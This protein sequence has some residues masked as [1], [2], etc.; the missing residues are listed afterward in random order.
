MRLHEKGGR[1]HEMPLNHNL[2]AYIEA[3]VSAVAI[4]GDA[5]GYLFRTTRATSRAL[6]LYR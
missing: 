1:C 3:Y 5:K 2:E 4:A 6:S